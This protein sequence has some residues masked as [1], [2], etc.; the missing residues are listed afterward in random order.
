MKQ[1][2]EF[3]HYGYF[4]ICPVMFADL[5]SG[6]PHI[7]PRFKLGWLM[8]ISESLIGLYFNFRINRDP[9]YEPMFPLLVKGE[10]K[11]PKI[12][13]FELDE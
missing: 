1:T 13:E 12:L 9:G 2:I 10:F 6:A 7:E 4:G 3:T 5:E 8:D 11:T